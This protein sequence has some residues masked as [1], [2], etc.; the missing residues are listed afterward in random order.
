MPSSALVLVAGLVGHPGASPDTLVAAGDPPHRTWHLALRAASVAESAPSAALVLHNALVQLTLGAPERARSLLLR[1][2]MP[3]G[4]SL[5]PAAYR[6]F[7]TAAYA[8]EDY[9]TAARYYAGAAAGAAGIRRGVLE[10]RAGEAFERAGLSR[11]AA[12]HYRVAMRYLPSVSGWVAIRLARLTPDTVRAFELLRA[13][14]E[15]ARALALDA[16]A[17]LLAAAGDHRRAIA[18]LVAARRNGRAA[19]IALASGDTARA[20]RLAFVA[21]AGADTAEAALALD[22]LAAR[23]LART[24]AERRAIAQAMERRARYPEAARWF[25][26]IVASGDS[27]AGALLAWGGALEQAGD[28]AAALRV[29]ALAEKAPGESDAATARYARARATLRRGRTAAGVAGLLSFLRR[30]PGHPSVPLALMAVAEARA[31]A[32]ARRAADSLYQLVVHDWSQSPSAAEARFLLAGRALARREMERAHSLYA[33]V[34]AAGG[35]NALAARFVLGRLALRNGHTAAATAQWKALALDDPLGYY[36][37][38]ARQAAGLDAHAFPETGPLPTTPAISEAILTLG[39]LDAVAFDAEAEHFVQYLVARD[40]YTPEQLLELA[41]GLLARGRPTVAA[42]LGW[43]AARGL[44]LADPRVLRVIFPWPWRELIEAEAQEFGV[45]PYLLAAV[46]R[47]ESGFRRAV[48]SR[49]GARGLMQLMPGTAA[50]TASRLGVPWR[51]RLLTV[52]DANLHL[53]AA[54]LAML[55]RRYR[56]AVVT[57]LAAYN[58]GARPVERWA[59]MPEARDPFWFVEGIPYPE[60]RGYVRS[61]VRNRALYEALYPPVEAR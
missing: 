24:Q 4:S 5:S 14:P 58:A 41:G 30:H 32:G 9:A 60:T 11:A 27:S 20:R 59:R 21:L 26:R 51:D 50:L 31:Q 8:D 44:S 10:A 3:R 40:G 15:P 33:A 48:T 28:R 46:V 29:L 23:S 35:P 6:L 25:G 34:A 19:A 22:L 55:L 12:A 38:L 16:R 7:A 37:T 43:R 47:Q 18:E 54:H 2:P 56:G 45:D 36:G 39:L 49:A 17:D 57:A 52:P 1:Y 13:V 42:S 61:V 53:G